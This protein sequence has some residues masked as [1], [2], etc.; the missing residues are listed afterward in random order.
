MTTKRDPAI[1]EL[2]NVAEQDL[3]GEKFVAR[4]MSRVDHLRRRSLVGWILVG[5]VLLAVG[6]LLAAPVQDAIQLLT[7]SLSISL[8]DLGD[9]WIAKMI[10]PANS[11]AGLVAFIL[12]VLL[13][14]YRKIFL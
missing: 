9:R 14:A 12:L 6:W 8:V 7:Q 13:A 11:V 2:F 5:L 3:A 10:S 4:T 1:L